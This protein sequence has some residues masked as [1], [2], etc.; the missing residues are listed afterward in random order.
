MGGLFSVGLCELLTLMDKNTSRPINSNTGALS[1][2]IC[3]SVFCFVPRERDRAL[4]QAGAPA[5]QPQRTDQPRFT[6]GGF[7]LKTTKSAA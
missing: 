4:A 2:I 3:K 6:G 7:N 5:I 1:S